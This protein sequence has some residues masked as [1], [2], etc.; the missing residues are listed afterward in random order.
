MP[1]PRYAVNG[2]SMPHTTALQD[3]E[4]VART[5]GQAVGLRESDM[6]DV[7][8]AELLEAMKDHGLAASF[9]V[10]QTW[11]ILPVPFN[12]P[13]MERD[14]AVRIDLICESIPRLAKFDPAVI[15]VGPGVTGVPGERAGPVDAVYE[16]TA[17]VA[18]VAAEH[19]LQI[20]FELLAER[21][22]ATFHT[23]A[24]T[25]AFMDDLGRD[26]VGLMFDTWHSWC[27]PGLHDN[28]REHGHRINSVHVNDVCPEERSN[29]D[30]ALPGEGRGVAASI[31]ATLIEVGYEGWWELEV[32]SDDGTF[33]DDFPDSLWKLPPEEMLARAKAAFDGVWADAL[34]IVEDRTRQP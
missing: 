1:T 31:I 19:G 30:R 6:G 2:W 32:F 24:E 3:I 13:G 8:D 5:G 17:R 22:G 15:I 23:I 14:P 29:F 25:I 27:E 33:G 26:N 16:G 20:G 7:T 34:Q 10:P 28:L 21:R 9:F 18:D 4:L 12:V 11:T